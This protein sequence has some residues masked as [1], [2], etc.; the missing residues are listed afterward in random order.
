MITGIDYELLAQ[1]R[2]SIEK[3]EKLLAGAIMLES[4]EQASIIKTHLDKAK[5]FLAEA[6]ELTNG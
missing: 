6:E 5:E 1:L 2:T 3:A 4:W